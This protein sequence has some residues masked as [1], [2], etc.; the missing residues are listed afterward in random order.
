MS[1]SKQ[2]MFGARLAPLAINQTRWT[3]IPASPMTSLS[4]T[5]VVP[6]TLPKSMQASQ[7]PEVNPHD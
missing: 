7:N 2:S 3:D 4:A 1:Y 5:A 6:G